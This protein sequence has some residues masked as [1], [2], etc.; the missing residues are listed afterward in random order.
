MHAARE[1][2]ILQAKLSVPHLPCGPKPHPPSTAHQV[3]RRPSGGPWPDWRAGREPAARPTG[4]LTWCRVA[5]ALGAL[6]L[7]SVTCTTA[8]G[9]CGEAAG[10]GGVSRAWGHPRAPGR[11]GPTPGTH[12]GDQT[13]H[14]C[15]SHAPASSQAWGR[16]A[17]VY[18]LGPLPAGHLRPQR[19]SHVFPMRGVRAP[20]RNDG[21]C[22]RPGL[23]PSDGPPGDLHPCLRLP[24]PT[25]HPSTLAAEVVQALTSRKTPHYYY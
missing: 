24:V 10:E 15:G 21:F 23:F 2:P 9:C 18:D 13:G 4:V 5:S 11:G 20:L 16:R 25:A 6:M 14:V 12:L 19:L 8:S 7:T 1:T 22:G 3:S 17:V